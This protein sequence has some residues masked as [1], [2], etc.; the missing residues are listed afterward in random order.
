MDAVG[1]VVEQLEE[2]FAFVRDLL[3]RTYQRTATVA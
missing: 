1:T 2:E 3:E